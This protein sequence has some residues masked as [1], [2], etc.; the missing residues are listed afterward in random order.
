MTE[1]GKGTPMK[2]GT[3]ASIRQTSSCYSEPAE[4]TETAL[5]DP[6]SNACREWTEC[7]DGFED[8]F[9]EHDLSDRVDDS[10]G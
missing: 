2:T 5:R 9:V 3:C 1:A 4:T 6:C 10:S 8:D 7:A